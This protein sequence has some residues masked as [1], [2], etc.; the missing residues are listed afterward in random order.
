MRLASNSLFFSVWQP[1]N[2]TQIR[3]I[4]KEMPKLTYSRWLDSQRARSLFLIYLLIGVCR[5][6]RMRCHFNSS[7]LLLYSFGET[8][9]INRRQFWMEK[10]TEQ[11]LT[12]L[13]FIRTTRYDYSE[14]SVRTERQILFT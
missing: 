14:L 10:L 8:H 7:H 13:N 3:P 9:D 11:E 4:K 12:A 6:E 5:S 2:Q 1:V